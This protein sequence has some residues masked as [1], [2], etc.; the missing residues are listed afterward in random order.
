MKYRLRNYV[1]NGSD[2]K[3]FYIFTFS[4]FDFIESW[5]IEHGN[6][7]EIGG[8][9]GVDDVAVL[10]YDFVSTRRKIPPF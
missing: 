2:T 6:L 10:G 9:H 4:T 5:H 8:F 7:C 3:L 1:Y